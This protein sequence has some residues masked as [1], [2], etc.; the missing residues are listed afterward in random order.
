MDRIARNLSVFQ[1]TVCCDFICL[2]FCCYFM[3]VCCDLWFES[4]DLVGI[5]GFEWPP[6]RQ[7]PFAGTPDAEPIPEPV[8]LCFS[9]LFIEYGPSE[10]WR[11]I[12]G[13]PGELRQVARLPPKPHRQAAKQI[14]VWSADHG[15]LKID[16]MCSTTRSA[17]RFWPNNRINMDKNN[18]QTVV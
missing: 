18:K 3:A 8:G 13:C 6:K 17:F 5:L 7:R 16:L 10:L 15:L 1:I 4:R 9:A 12:P 11:V 2:L 14:K